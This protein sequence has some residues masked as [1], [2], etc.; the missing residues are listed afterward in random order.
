MKARNATPAMLA[1]VALLCIPSELLATTPLRLDPSADLQYGA[2]VRRLFVAD[3]KV[4]RCSDSE[5]VV[6]LK[7]SGLIEGTDRAAWELELRI[8]V[9]PTVLAGDRLVNLLQ[10]FE[11]VLRT[12]TEIE[13][14]EWR[15]RSQNGGPYLA[16][17][18]TLGDRVVLVLPTRFDRVGSDPERLFAVLAVEC[19][20]K[21]NALSCTSARF[22]FENAFPALFGSTAGSEGLF[23]PAVRALVRQSARDFERNLD[24]QSDPFDCCY[25][26]YYC[27]C[28]ICQDEPERCPVTCW[29]CSVDAC[30]DCWFVGCGSC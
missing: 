25:S 22:V 2:G 15:A 12:E 29:N 27:G 19:H 9:G 13:G 10:N 1:V 18:V 23:P 26:T 7:A 8:H 21:Q 17:T 4:P 6:D 11:G 3:P 28:H 30:F 24:P 14:L 16:R 5:S 20:A